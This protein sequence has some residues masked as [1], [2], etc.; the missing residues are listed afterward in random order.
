M[1][2]AM[3]RSAENLEEPPKILVLKPLGGF[4]R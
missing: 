3:K 1:A 2:E 4:K